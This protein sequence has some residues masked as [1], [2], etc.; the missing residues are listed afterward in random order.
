M[1][2]LSKLI[3]TRIAET[4]AQRIGL[5]V[6]PEY[7]AHKRAE[8]LRELER[9]AVITYGV[10]TGPEV[11]VQSRYRMTLE[12]YLDRLQEES[13]ERYLFSHLI[14]FYAH[15]E[16]RIELQ[17]I[18]TRSE[19][20]AKEVQARLVEG[21]DFSRLAMRYS[22]DSSA[23]N[24]GRLPPLPRVA[25]E[26]SVG[27]A[28]FGLAVGERSGLL[29]VVSETGVRQIQILRVVAHLPGQ[30]G[31]YSEHAAKLAAELDERPIS[32]DEWSAWYLAM[33]RLYKVK[34]SPNL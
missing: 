22:E 28:V 17:L 3:G 33:E 11:L 16:T 2:S 23:P 10:G 21:A 31:T 12:S 5:V 27:D 14:R 20:I 18:A 34:L 6:P 25:L 26:P 15:H 32:A 13:H 8:H 30:P 7:L 1:A 9:E 19:S 4:E 29:S 24:G